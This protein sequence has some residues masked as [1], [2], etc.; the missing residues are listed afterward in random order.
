MRYLVH[1]H[2]WEALID[3]LHSQGGLGTALQDTI[4]QTLPEFEA[5]W[6]E[7]VAQGHTLPEWIEI[8]W[9]FD[10]EMVYEYTNKWNTVA[11]VS[12]SPAS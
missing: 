2:G 1:T 6:L 4:G 7:S 12:D 9:A 5:A 10:P 8:A 11:V 3:L